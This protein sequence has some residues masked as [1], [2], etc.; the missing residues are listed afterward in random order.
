MSGSTKARN[1][2][3]MLLSSRAQPPK[4]LKD[5]PPRSSNRSNLSVKQFLLATSP[6]PSPALPALVP[7]HG[8]KPP[9]VNTRRALR[10]LSWLA[11]LVTFY[12][13]ASF[14]LASTKQ[15]VITRIPSSSYLSPDTMEEDLSS[16]NL[17]EYPTPI[18]VVDKLNRQKWTISIPSKLGFPLQAADYADICA[19]VPDVATHMSSK[20]QSTTFLD[21]D[22]A[23]KAGILPQETHSSKSHVPVCDRTLIYVLD[24]TDAGLGST[25]MGLWLS[26]SL[27]KRESRSFF[28]DD[29]HFA[30]GRYSTYFV[31]PSAPKCRPPS[32][33]HRLP[34][35]PQAKHLVISAATHPWIFGKDFSSTY[36][37][38]EIFSMAREGYEALFH[39]R[40]DDAEYVDKRISD[41]R[42]SSPNNKIVGVHSRRGD[43]HPFTLA[44]SR[45]YLPPTIYSDTAT[46]LA[47]QL[48]PKSS[49]E[50]ISTILASDDP[51]LY[52][53]GSPL[54]YTRAQNRI[55][56]ASKST[57]GDGSI[58]WEGGFF[59]AL[60][61]NLGLPAEAEW[62]KRI[63]SPLPS[64]MVAEMGEEARDERDFRTRPTKEAVEM[65]EL[66]GRAYLLDL[67]VL[68]RAD[69]VVCAVSSYTCRLLGV[70]MGE[71]A[72]REGRWAN[73]EE[74][75]PWL[76]VDS[77][78]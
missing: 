63:G 45:N 66:I 25:L 57:L 73:V 14:L 22:E 38:H 16:S 37:M 36:T 78:V 5:F 54:P 39:L 77:S 75:Y 12:Y 27:A 20:T 33:S 11:I 18:G 31:P 7:R 52:A 51:E 50:G 60:F 13:L 59:A 56:L 76:A 58:G 44:Y 69:G 30:Y 48:A 8:K 34:Y 3:T 42:G 28:I 21:V 43:R 35:P 68:G 15:V 23:Q 10:V 62:Q 29:R 49:S 6:L 24:G 72:V 64:R 46:S 53:D 17:P 74:G 19:H 2:G 26:Y 1:G 61:W 41:L 65:R 4:A 67:A 71:Q 9:P 47:S 55:T 40:Q 32:T 70:M